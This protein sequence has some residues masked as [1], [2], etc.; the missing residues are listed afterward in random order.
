MAYHPR[1]AQSVRDD[2]ERIR[3]HPLVPENIAVYGYIYDVSSGS[4]VEVPE[5]Q[6][7]AVAA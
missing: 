2:V 3:Q 5:A 4:L 6:R 1:Q 7:S